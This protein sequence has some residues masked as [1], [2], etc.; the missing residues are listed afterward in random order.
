MASAFITAGD[1]LAVTRDEDTIYIR[2]AYTLTV[3]SLIFERANEMG[4]VGATLLAFVVGWAGPAFGD[5]PCTPA[6]VLSLNPLL[7]IVQDTL[8]K[9]SEIMSEATVSPDPNLASTAG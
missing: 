6:N 1:K 2:S 5:T 8:V 3:Q 9:V 4:K 7:P